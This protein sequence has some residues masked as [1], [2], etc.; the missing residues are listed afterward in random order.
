[1]SFSGCSKTGRVV[2]GL[3]AVLAVALLASPLQA[4]S[5]SNPKWDI[6]VGYQWLHPGGW[7]PTPFT[8][9]NAPTAFRVPDMPAGFGGAFT[10]NFDSHLGLE[11]DGGDNWGSSNYEATASVGPRLMF[12][13]DNA[14]YFLHTLIG[15]NRLNVSGLNPN[16]G[17]GA[18]I[19]GGMDLPITK[20]FAFRLFEADFDWAH[21]NYSDYVADEFASLRRSSFDGV[22]LRT[23]LVFSWGGEAPI[24]PSATCSVQPTEVMVGEPITA[25]ASANNFNPKH[26]VTYAWSATGGQINGKDTTAQIDTTNAAPGNYS[27]TARA[28]DAR[29][30][31]NNEASCSASF[32]VKPLPPKNP[33]TMSISANPTSLQAGGTVDLQANC[34]SPD[35]VPVSV[36]SWTATGGKVYGTGGSATLS[37]TG[38][39]PGPITV[40]ATCTDSRGLTAQASS[41][42]TIETPPPPKNPEIE[43]LEARLSLHSIYFPT[44]LPPIRDPNAGLVPSQRQTLIAL[45]ADFKKYLESKPEAHLILEGHADPRGP[46]EFNQK[47]SERRDNRVKSFL[48]EQGIPEAN[49]DEK[50]FGAQRTLTNE[51]VRNAIENN[52]NLTQEERERALRNMRVIVLA[53]D[54]RVDITLSTT[55][56]SSV[57]QFPFNSADALTLI[58]GREG[59]MKKK[60]AR[61]APKRK[62]TGN[63]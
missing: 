57:R 55:G 22:L 27:V 17:L 13:T 2:A 10:Y 59:E 14:N 15:L 37:T 20:K 26:T 50:A 62:K 34:T 45:A 11:F 4:Q 35:S 61:P 9:F 38:A 41:E 49:I 58:G 1:M 63:Q 25:T 53:S 39:S 16:N 6:F 60:T 31:R 43:V 42:V 28:T 33:P 56:Q 12:R 36:A 24:A 46:A 30:K 47:L 19:G 54:R 44:N 18:L 51:E 5:D 8:D 29:E 23:G 7:T 32:T 52:P 21:H 3:L 48:V 40:S